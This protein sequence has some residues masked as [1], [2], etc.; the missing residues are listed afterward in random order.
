MLQTNPFYRLSI[1]EVLNHPY[2]ARYQ[3]PRPKKNYFDRYQN[4]GLKQGEQNRNMNNI[5]RTVQNNFCGC[6][7]P[8]AQNYSSYDLNLHLGRLSMR[9]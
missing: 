7:N 1:N 9:K 3:Q 6:H 5:E 2:F 4:V 8:L